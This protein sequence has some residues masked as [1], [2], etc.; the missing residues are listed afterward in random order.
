M[1][2]IILILTIMSALLLHLTCRTNRH[3]REHGSV[4]MGLEASVDDLDPRTATDANSSRICSL[5]YSGLFKKGRDSGIVPDIVKNY[6]VRDDRIFIFYLK[7]GI[8][9]HNGS[10]LTSRDVKY[11]FDSLLEEDFIS[12]KK[13][14]Y[15]IIKEIAVIDDYTVSFELREVFSPFIDYLTIGIIPSGIDAENKNILKTKPVGSGPFML[16]EFREGISLKLERYDNYF[17]EK[18]QIRTL[19]FRIIADTTTRLL[20]LENKGIDIVQNDIPYD[21]IQRFEKSRDY[22]VISAQGINYQY[23]GFNLEDK[24]LSNNDIRKA[25]TYSINRDVIIEHIYKG[26]V[27]KA[28]SVL[29]PLNWAYYNELEEYGYD[30]PKA[31]NLIENAGYSKNKDGYYFDLEYK[32]SENIQALTIAQIIQEQLRDAGI[33]VNI[34]SREWGTFYDDIKKGDFQL[35]S[36]RWVGISDP[37]IYYYIMSS[38]S[39]PPDGANRGRYKNEEVDRLIAL[40]RI[41]TD[42]ELRRNYYCRIQKILNETL[43]Y[44]HLWYHSNIII[45]ASTISNVVPYPDGSFYFL[46]DISLD[47]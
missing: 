37:D 47:N 42:T 44:V 16:R 29:S 38:D 6:E 8:L 40:A 31:V 1:K 10:E 18:P 19:F 21:S 15:E 34:V 7:Q 5:I 22:N 2:R 35:F 30:I 41:T 12:F 13:A 46:L 9:F 24:I 26:Y 4:I 32:T 14:S 36:L 28:D 45:S 11:T 20:E 27:T 23:L 43:P 25:V 39:I 17:D 33:R 3:D